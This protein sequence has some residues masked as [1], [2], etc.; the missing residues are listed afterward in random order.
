MAREAIAVDA[1]GSNRGDSFF[2]VGTALHFSDLDGFRKHY[3]DVL[4]SFCHEFNI[5]T[6]AHCMFGSPGET[7]DTVEQSIR[8]IKEIDPTIITFGITT[9]YPG[10]P[11]FE[12]VAA[13]HPEIGDGSQMDIGRLHTDSFFNQF[14]TDLSNDELSQ[15][16]RRVYREFYFRPGYIWSWIKRI[17]SWAEFK[18]V[19]MAGANVLDFALS[20][21]N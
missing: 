21:G 12:E 9:P 6:H 2:L 1:S 3:L 10:T 4:G 15:D 18:Q 19:A 14:F 11:L 5:D 13:V 20:R 16:I 7:R 8:F 17:D